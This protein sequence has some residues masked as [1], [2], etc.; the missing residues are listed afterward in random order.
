MGK[1]NV[2]GYYNIVKS[3][4][5]TLPENT[6]FGNFEHTVQSYDWFVP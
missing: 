1:E 6:N 2:E 5:R 4:N 3:F